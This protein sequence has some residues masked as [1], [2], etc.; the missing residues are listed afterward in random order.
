MREM[1]KNLYL[2]NFEFFTVVGILSCKVKS[3]IELIKFLLDF[4]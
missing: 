4:K 1:L 3:T 2:I